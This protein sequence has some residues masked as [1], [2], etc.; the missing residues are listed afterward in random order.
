VALVRAPWLVE[1]ADSGI[2]ALP[3]RQDMPGDAIWSMDELFE[4][5]R[6]G[7]RK[8]RVG[9]EIVAVSHCW[10]TPHHPDPERKQ[11]E[12]LGRFLQ[13][14]TNT[15]PG[16]LLK[17]IAVFIDWCSLMQ[18]PRTDAEQHLFEHALQH[19]SLW[20]AHRL[21]RVWMLTATAEGITPYQQRGWPH[22]EAALATINA[23]R[24]ADVLDIGRCESGARHLDRGWPCTTVGMSALVDAN[25]QSLDEATLKICAPPR[26]PP[27]TPKAFAKS[28]ETKVFKRGGDADMLIQ[29]YNEYFMAFA[30]SVETLDMSGLGWEDLDVEK[31]ADSLPFF[32]QLRELNLANN[33]ITELGAGYLADEIPK[34]S[35]LKKL[36]LAGNKI[37]PGLE[38]SERL[39]ETWAAASKDDFWLFL[40]YPTHCDYVKRK[41]GIE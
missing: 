10:L 25:S 14:W 28:L 17:R 11:A 16:L 22:F 34:C 8:L 13:A 37:E 1:F 33:E 39:I 21:V 41:I 2:G 20:Y 12:Q 31:V 4:M 9:H 29:L 15:Q 30:S 3:R 7:S 40:W 36:F 32:G 23:H 24:G 5:T 26:K 38:G 19:A 18:E 6:L 35:S 27:M